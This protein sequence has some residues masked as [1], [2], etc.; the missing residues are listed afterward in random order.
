[1]PLTKEVQQ[2]MGV[3]I[4][5]SSHWH[6]VKNETTL[7]LVNKH[8]SR[9]QIMKTCILTL[10]MG[11]QGHH[12]QILAVSWN[13]CTLMLHC[14]QQATAKPKI[15]H[16]V[17]LSSIDISSKILESKQI[18]RFTILITYI[19]IWCEVKIL[20]QDCHNQEHNTNNYT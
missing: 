6:K 11:H 12:R 18:L 5:C 14:I 1:M 9:K 20:K 4:F 3:V 10:S 17:L 19:W 2:L 15:I 13:K 16:K 8:K 7:T